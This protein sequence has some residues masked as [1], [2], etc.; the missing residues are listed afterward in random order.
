MHVKLTNAHRLRTI[1]TPYKI[2]LSGGG[3]EQSTLQRHFK[4]KFTVMSSV[5][6]CSSNTATVKGTV[7]AGATT[8]EY[9]Y[10]EGTFKA[11]FE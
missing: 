1:Q 8:T 5:S 10:I 2:K 11:S 3:I 4:T 9:R 6:L 7:P